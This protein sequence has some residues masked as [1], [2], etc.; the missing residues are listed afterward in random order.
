MDSCPPLCPYYQE[1]HSIKNDARGLE[2][3]KCTM[4]QE[5]KPAEWKWQSISWWK[6]SVCHHSPSCQLMLKDDV[7]YSFISLTHLH[8]GLNE[9]TVSPSSLRCRLGKQGQKSLSASYTPD[10]SAVH[11]HN[12]QSMILCLLLFFQLQP[13]ISALSN[14]IWKWFFLFWEWQELFFDKRSEV[15]FFELLHYST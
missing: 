11:L 10:L 5:W 9:D 6:C 2:I 14:L 8:R 3:R 13:A 4:S 7:S 12:Y 1:T 15:K